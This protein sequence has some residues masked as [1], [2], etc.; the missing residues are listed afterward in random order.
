MESD[1]TTMGMTVNIWNTWIMAGEHMQYVDNGWKVSVDGWRPGL[2]QVCG[3]AGVPYIIYVYGV[4][5]CVGDFC[6]SMWSTMFT[7]VFGH[8][9]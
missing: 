6:V 7:A 3:S 2:A 8:F 4:F 5:G 1:P 9:S